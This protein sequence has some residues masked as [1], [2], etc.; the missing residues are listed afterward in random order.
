VSLLVAVTVTLGITEPLLSFT[1][2]VRAPV[3]DD[4][5]NSDT[6]EINTRQKHRTV[7]QTLLPAIAIIIGSLSAHI[8]LFCI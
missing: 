5:A 7:W 6:P 3:P 1:V 8:N 4:C 2:P